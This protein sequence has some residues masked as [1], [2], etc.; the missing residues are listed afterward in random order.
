[1]LLNPEKVLAPNVSYALMP[2][3]MITGKSFAY[4]K[5]LSQY[6]SGNL[7]DYV[8]ARR[9]VNIQDKA[10]EIANYAKI[11]EEILF[12]SLAKPQHDKKP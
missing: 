5:K 7:T 4:G 3:G 8:G 12:A 2:N 1:M 9:I 6:L 11:F 10:I